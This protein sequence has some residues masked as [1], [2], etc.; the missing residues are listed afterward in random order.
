MQ[1][2]HPLFPC[3]SVAESDLQQLNALDRE[4]FVARLGA[5][6]EHSPWVAQ[7][8]WPGR[9]F[10]SLDAL[11]AVMHGVVL[12]ASR[13]AQLALI[14]A[15]PE[16]QGKVAQPAGLT[17]ASRSEQTGAGLDRLMPEQHA[18]LQTL[19]RA[20]RERFGFPFVVAVRGL[21]AAR[22]IARI[23]SRLANTPEQEFHACLDEI[24]RIAR[25]RLERLVVT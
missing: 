18:K 21:D 11:H 4:A 22:I 20:Y 6:Y 3:A 2:G 9:P 12:S 15:H 14:R 5:I 1:P 17:E 13:D 25:F 16:L 19:N 8:A 24:G 10:G 7:G 23:E